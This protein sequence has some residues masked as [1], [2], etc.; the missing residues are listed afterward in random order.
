VG[1]VP[2]GGTLDLLEEIGDV[3]GDARLHGIAAGVPKDNPVLALAGDRWQGD[4]S[5]LVPAVASAM[6]QGRRDS[7]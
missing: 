2:G 6:F 3:E 7:K 4:V 5:Y 1:H